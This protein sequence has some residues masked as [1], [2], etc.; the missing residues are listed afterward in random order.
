MGD[1]RRRWLVGVD[2]E[3]ARLG[4][5]ALAWCF[6]SLLAVAVLVRPSA[7][8]L[9]APVLVLA[10]PVAGLLYALWNGG[11]FVAVV[12]AEGAV[13]ILDALGLPVPQAT[14]LYA[15]ALP[16]ALLAFA[17]GATRSHLALRGPPPLGEGR[18]GRVVMFLWVPLV[19]ALAWALTVPETAWP[20]LA[21]RPW[22]TGYVRGVATWGL[23]GAALGWA[24][25]RRGPV[26]TFLLATT[27]AWARALGDVLGAAPRTD[28][29]LHLG[30]LFLPPELAWWR[31]FA[32]VA[33]G[34][35]AMLA[36]I[37][38]EPAWPWLPWNQ[39]REVHQV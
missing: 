6:F 1:T 5:W 23:A 24:I 28:P 29:A 18:A 36:A 9:L 13:P 15:I 35:G 25:A 8:G 2:L 11:P 37:A 39:P 32:L 26:L 21:G 16:G 27:P 33:T 19:A 17:A 22:W 7:R 20:Q 10:M 30:E 3:R 12:A 14:A 4:A 34:V 38:F 31:G